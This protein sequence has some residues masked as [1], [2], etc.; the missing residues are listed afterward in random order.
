MTV[1]VFI[2][3]LIGGFLVYWSLLALAVRRA[4]LE[5]GWGSSIFL[6]LGMAL[7][8]LGIVLFIV[9]LVSTIVTS[10]SVPL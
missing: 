3:L 6:G 4:T 2:L 10:W 8:S 1:G 5:E 7:A 9:G